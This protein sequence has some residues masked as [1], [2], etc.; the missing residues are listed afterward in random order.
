MGNTKALRVMWSP[1]FKPADL[2]GKTPQGYREGANGTE[3]EP[4]TYGEGFGGEAAVCLLDGD[5]GAW[6]R[7]MVAAVGGVL[8]APDGEVTDYAVRV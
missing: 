5:D 8:Y 1:E 4:G 6:F 7:K 2:Q 3:K